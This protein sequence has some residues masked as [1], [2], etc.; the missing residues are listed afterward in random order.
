MASAQNFGITAGSLV[1]N[2]LVFQFKIGLE[3]VLR[4]V[5]IFIAVFTAVFF[6]KAE[7]AKEKEVERSNEDEKSK[8]KIKGQGQGGESWEDMFKMFFHIMR[9]PSLLLFSFFVLFHRLPFGPIDFTFKYRLVQMGVSTKELSGLVSIASLICLALP[10]FTAHLLKNKNE[11]I[12]FLLVILIKYLENF[13]SLY[14]LSSGSFSW[15][16]VFLLLLFQHLF[17]NASYILVS[18]I[19]SKIANKVKGYEATSLAFFASLMNL[20]K[21]IAEIASIKGGGRVEGVV[22]GWVGGVILF[23]GVGRKLA[24][25]LKVKEM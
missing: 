23:M 1:S 16:F 22:L 9:S 15:I 17:F 11:L 24:R 7:E 8:S 18:S 25:D 12:V 4:G 21:R 5:G 20:A 6:F 19:T 14:L 10:L 13:A 3:G 2:I